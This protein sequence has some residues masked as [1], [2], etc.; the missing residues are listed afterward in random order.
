MRRIEKLLAC[1]PYSRTGR[2]LDKRSFGVNRYYY[3]YHREFWL[4][5]MLAICSRVSS[6]AHAQAA[7]SPGPRPAQP[8]QLRGARPKQVCTSLRAL[9]LGGAAS[10]IRELHCPQYYARRHLSQWAVVVPGPGH[11]KAKGQLYK[12]PPELFLGG[13]ETEPSRSSRHLGSAKTPLHL[14]TPEA[15]STCRPARGSSLAPC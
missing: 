1:C 14:R 12:L 13:R 6:F 8:S 2:D 7:G 5:H 4:P 9:Q 3:L 10:M 15:L 11:C